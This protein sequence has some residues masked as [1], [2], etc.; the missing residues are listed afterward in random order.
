MIPDYWENQSFS[1]AWS[2]IPE[3]WAFI[4]YLFFCHAWSMW[5]GGCYGVGNMHALNQE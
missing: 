1:E 4:Y 3:K 2:K 5:D